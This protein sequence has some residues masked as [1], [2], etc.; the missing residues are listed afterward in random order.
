MLQVVT[1]NTVYTHERVCCLHRVEGPDHQENTEIVY[2]DWSRQEH[3]KTVHFNNFAENLLKSDIDVLVRLRVRR[4]RIKEI[5]VMR[6]GAIKR[7]GQ[8]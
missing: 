5:S 7:R 2:Q 1:K 3:G 4:T 8:T 6:L